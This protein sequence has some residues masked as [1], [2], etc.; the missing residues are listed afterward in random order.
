MSVIYLSVNPD[1][2]TIKSM[3]KNMLT[4]KE[5][6][7]MFIDN[8]I[9][10]LRRCIPP[11]FIGPL[12]KE[13]DKAQEQKQRI[14][15]E[16]RI[17]PFAEQTV[18]PPATGKQHGSNIDAAVNEII[19]KISGKKPS[20]ESFGDDDIDDLVR[21]VV[22]DHLDQCDQITKDDI[23]AITRKIIDELD[24]DDITQEEIDEISSKVAASI[25]RLSFGQKLQKQTPGAVG[26]Q[27]LQEQ[28]PESI[29]A[30]VQQQLGQAQRSPSGFVPYQ[31]PQLGQQQ[32]EQAPV[33]QHGSNSAMDPSNMI[34][35]TGSTDDLLLKRF[36]EQQ[37]KDKTKTIDD[38]IMEA[39]PD[40]IPDSFARSIRDRIMKIIKE[41]SAQRGIEILQKA[42]QQAYPSEDIDEYVEDIH[43]AIDK[44]EDDYR[45]PPRA[46]VQPTNG[47]PDMSPPPG[48][49]FAEKVADEPLP[50]FLPDRLAGER[51]KQSLDQQ[52]ADLVEQEAF[53]Q[54]QPAASAARM[55]GSA[56][57]QPSPAQQDGESLIEKVK[58]EQRQLLQP[59]T[60]PVSH[61]AEFT[62][63]PQGQPTP[64]VAGSMRGSPV[65]MDPSAGIG[66]QSSEA[67]A[68]AAAET[69]PN[70]IPPIDPQ[71]G[72]DTMVG[73]AP[74]VAPLS[75]NCALKIAGD[76]GG[77]RNKK[78]GVIKKR[79]G[80]VPTFPRG[81]RGIHH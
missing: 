42:I 28:T 49:T 27:Q 36:Q 70:L 10:A 74:Q 39:I 52:V 64:N 54:P 25:A 72:S 1:N 2:K 48:K 44:I 13:W 33:R 67:D 58:E 34:T 79:S 14:L 66:A 18:Q 12:L 19:Q 47:A 77:R 60:Q 69:D 40:N 21:E 51:F 32:Q 7:Q 63:A 65:A 71:S 30:S 38:E 9:D 80:G 6:R 22:D 50:E 5:L 37:Q 53:E 4:G 55:S 20:I 3:R 23:A 16:K 57:N 29:V 56:T 78:L 59:E 31:Q 35:I 61:E 8:D 73:V 75:N 11:E 24:H 43:E 46:F 68:S 62:P 76:M 15:E 45:R 26:E 41:S 17:E 81:I